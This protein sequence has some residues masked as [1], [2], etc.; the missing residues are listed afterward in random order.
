MKIYNGYERLGRNY[1]LL[2]DDYEYTMG[3]G[4]LLSEQNQKQ[5]AFDIFFRKVP[6]EGG[7]S[8]MAGLDKIIAYIQNLK[9]TERELDYFR[10]KGHDEKFID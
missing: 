2:N 3:G 9:F 8:V 4:Y 7:Y 1:S 6:N 10:R 5:A